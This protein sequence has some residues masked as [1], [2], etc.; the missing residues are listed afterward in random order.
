MVTTAHAPTRRRRGFH[1]RLA[2][3]VALL[4]LVFGLAGFAVT[5]LGGVTEIRSAGDL[6]SLGEEGSLLLGF[7]I[8]PVHNVLHVVVGLLGLL[9]WARSGSARLF[10]LILLVGY[11]A[12]YLYGRLALDGRMPNYLSLNAADNWLHLGAAAVGLV[13]MLWP[14]RRRV[15][16]PSPGPRR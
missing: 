16:A 9:L 15:D 5:G 2:L 4:F 13:I 1:Q 10:G 12:V 8:N 14:A 6:P 7:G 3:L 11:G